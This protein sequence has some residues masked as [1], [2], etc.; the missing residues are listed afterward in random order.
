MAQ[1][2]SNAKKFDGAIAFYSEEYFRNVDRFIENLE[3]NQQALIKERD[4]IDAIDVK[5]KSQLDV[6]GSF[7]YDEN[8]E[9]EQK[10]SIARLEKSVSEID[11]NFKPSSI[12]PLSFIGLTICNRLA[13]EPIPRSL[14]ARI[15]GPVFF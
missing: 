11:A 1:I 14:M 8:Y 5:I 4:L 7:T 9:K 3:T 15:I 2:L 6:A 13:T 10:D 12:I